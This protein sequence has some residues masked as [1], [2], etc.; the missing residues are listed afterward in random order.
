MMLID[1]TGLTQS[2]AAFS[3]VSNATFAQGAGV[4]E[5]ISTIVYNGS[6]VAWLERMQV[7]LR[8]PDGALERIWERPDATAI[9]IGHMVRLRSMS[10]TDQQQS[11]AWHCSVVPSRSSPVASGIY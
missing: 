7:I 9:Y 6:Y 2:F 5:S 11:V 4:R 3:S 10:I 8:E 1:S